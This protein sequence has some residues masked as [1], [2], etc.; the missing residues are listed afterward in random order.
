MTSFPPIH[1][2]VAKYLHHKFPDCYSEVPTKPVV[3]VM[4]QLR[5]HFIQ[6]STQNVTNLS[7][8]I[9]DLF[10][11]KFLCAYSRQNFNFFEQPTLK[12]I[13]PGLECAYGPTYSSF[14]SSGQSAMASLLLALNQT[15]R[16]FR[17]F[18]SNRPYFETPLALKL[19]TKETDPQAD[20]IL[21]IDSTNFAPSDLDDLPKHINESVAVI[22]D[23]SCWVW[24]EP[25]LEKV[26]QVAG[27]KKPL[28]LVRSHLKI[29]CLGGEYASLGSI[30]FFAPKNMNQS[31][32][33]KVIDGLQLASSAIGSYPTP[34]H[35][36]PFY[37]D[38]EFHQLTY[39]RTLAIQKSVDRFAQALFPLVD[40]TR[41]VKENPYHRLFILLNFR[42]K[43][44]DLRKYIL[45]M[46]R[47]ADSPVVLADSYGFDFPSVL[48]SEV[49][50]DP[51]NTFLRIN[52]HT[53]GIE[54]EDE[55]IDTLQKIVQTAN[56]FALPTNP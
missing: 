18:S 48:V 10:G 14:H 8:E 47:F 33:E 31:E 26:L 56:K 46:V 11:F 27:E 50:S 55:I 13:Y 38:P 23:T 19:L 17:L 6:Q 16:G 4:Q 29:D 30:V 44:K 41:I 43:D 15:W 20:Q 3:E 1:S 12:D 51:D 21:L 40:T 42:C 2:K 53:L 35:I 24:N 45:K 37:K 32:K 34:D 5:G 39:E 52:G 25:L 49:K 54:R 22:I 36:F 28:Y 9:M 7:L